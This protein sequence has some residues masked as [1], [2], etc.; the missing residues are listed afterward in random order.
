MIM[1]RRMLLTAGLAASAAACA[2][3][4][5]LVEPGAYSK[6]AGLS[7]TLGRQWSDLTFMLP[8]RP[9]NVRMLS[10][11]G[12][13]L[14]RLFVAALEPGQGL[15]RPLDRDTPRPIFRADMSD[16]EAVEFVIDSL[17]AMQMEAPEATALRLQAMGAAAGIRFDI[18]TR[19]AQGLNLSGTALIARSDERLR[20]LIYIAPS[21]HYYAALLPEVEQ[22]LAS[23]AAA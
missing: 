8:N 1:N 11:D 17:A 6:A 9:P 22:I 5:G 19:T 15:V 20:A 13:L 23:A 2:T 12:P 18:S 10:V 14:N 3:G 16:T 7:I 21:E 4:G